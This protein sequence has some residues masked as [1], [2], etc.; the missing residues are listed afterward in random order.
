VGDHAIGLHGNVLAKLQPLAMDP[1]GV[2]PGRLR[3]IDVG[4]EVVADVPCLMRRCPGRGERMLEDFAFWLACRTPS[5]TI[6][7]MWRA[8][9]WRSIRALGLP[10]RS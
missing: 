9:S 10:W 6:A 8:R 2:D 3:A 5:I 1:D 7:S 4:V